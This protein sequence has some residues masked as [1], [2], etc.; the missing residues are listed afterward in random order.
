MKLNQPQQEA[1]K[2]LSG[3]LLVLAGAGSGK[4]RV[5]TNKI[6]YLINE[7]EIPAKNIYAVTFTNKAAN[8]MVKRVSQLAKNKLTR[9]LHI[10][11]FHALGLEIIRHEHVH[12]NLKKRFSIFDT[13]DVVSLL[14]DIM[15]QEKFNLPLEVDFIQ[16]QISQWKNDL[17]SSA[18]VYKKAQNPQ[19]IEIAKIYELYEKTLIAYNAVD[20]DDLILQPVQLLRKEE[21]VL[22]KWQERVH[23]LLV[24][25][26][27]DTNSCQYELIKLLTGLRQQFTVVGDDDQSIYA[28]RGAKAE[29][30]ILLKENYPH[31]QVIKLEQNYRSYGRI[32]KAA[33]KL[34]SHNPHM[35]EK[36]L[37]SDLGFGGQ[38]KVIVC[39][40]EL[41]EAERVV[42]ELVMHQFKYRAA[43]KDYAILY[44]G[45]FQARI[46]EQVLRDQQIP[47]YLSGGMS[48]FERSEVKDLLA[49]LRLLVNPDDDAA[50]LRVVNLPRRGIGIQTLEHLSAYAKQRQISLLQAVNE[51]G[52][53]QFLQGA[54]L[55]SLRSFADLINQKIRV[56]E[57]I[58]PGKLILE[59]LDDI[60]Y[61]NWLYENEKHTK[62]AAKKMENLLAFVQWIEKL[63]A[64]DEEAD[65][66]SIINKIMLI[67]RLSQGEEQENDQVQ[68]MTLHAAKGLEFP[69]VFLV[70]MEEELLPHRS[71]IDEENIEEERRLAYV[72]ITRAQKELTLTLAKTRKKQGEL[73]ACEPSRFLQEIAAEDL[74]WHGDG[75]EKSKEESQ[76]QAK[77]H[78][79]SLKE[80]LQS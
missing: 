49:Y 12:L 53:E 28:W 40:N 17:L 3:P 26:Y 78:L 71:S 18:E 1:I 6:A 62:G 34:I 67:D 5:I 63:A 21:K 43:Y 31:L 19:E 79:A 39:K 37:W 35:F 13:F 75:V 42:H 65:F 24:D 77:T 60:G 11:T 48:F 55:K 32:L 30:L 7:C 56:L 2:Y 9:G 22:K 50:F 41:H 47:Y 66:S 33:N 27:Q 45:N 8:E 14:R 58:A 59:L 25:E 52:L 76:E 70:G 4:T 57:E 36:K 54:G 69:Y 72:G 10:S 44:R 68:L 38:I 20:F 64:K 15:K 16:S 23:Y 74:E 61:E 51:I 80:M 73:V 29:N 46:F